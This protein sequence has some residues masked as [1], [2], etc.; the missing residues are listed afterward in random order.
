MQWAA[1]RQISAVGADFL[2]PEL[3]RAAV[4]VR[5]IK[6][7]RPVEL[8]GLQEAIEDAQRQIASLRSEISSDKNWVKTFKDGLDTHSLQLAQLIQGLKEERESRHEEEKIIS[9]KIET[10]RGHVLGI[11]WAW[12]LIIFLA[13]SAVTA[14]ITWGLP[15]IL[16]HF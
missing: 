1:S 14:L 7:Y 3:Q 8:R 11:R 12:G 9:G 15:K 5:L 10:L 16:A 13:G 4:E 2:P 6:N